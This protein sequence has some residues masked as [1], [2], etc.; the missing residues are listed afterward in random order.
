MCCE[1]LTALLVL[2]D[3]PWESSIEYPPLVKWQLQYYSGL[4]NCQVDTSVFFA[5]D[6]RPGGS[7]GLQPPNV[8]VFY[9]GCRAIRPRLLERGLPAAGALETSHAAPSDTST[10]SNRS[11]RRDRWRGRV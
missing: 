5:N 9:S 10:R 4:V 11:C 6:F 3:L 1:L 8:Y 7:S 2:S